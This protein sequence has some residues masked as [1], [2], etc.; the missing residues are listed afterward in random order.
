MEMPPFDD[1]GCNDRERMGSPGHHEFQTLNGA[2][3]DAVP[4]GG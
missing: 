2:S 4:Q 1:R 3:I